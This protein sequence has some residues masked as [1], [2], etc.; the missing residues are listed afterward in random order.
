[1][2]V[3]QARAFLREHGVRNVLAQFVDIHGAPKTKSVPIAHLEDV[4]TNGAGFAG[5][6][7]WGLGMEPQDPDFEAIGDLS[8]LCLLPWQP[9]YARIICS[10][11]VQGR[12]WPYDTRNILQTQ[13][14]RLHDRGMDLNTG[15][16]PEF[17]LL[18]RT[19]DGGVAPADPTDQ[20]MKPCYDYRSLSRNR[21]FLDRFV[22]AMEAVG[23]DVVQADHED[24]NGQFEVNTMYADALESADRLVFIKMAVTEIAHE[25]GMIGTFMPK[26]MTDRT[27]NGLHFHLSLCDERGTNLF[28]DTGDERG[29]DLSRMAYNFLGGLMHHAPALCALSAPTVNSYKRLVIG[30]SLSG[31]PWAPAYVSFGADNR[32]AMVRVPG[33]RLENRI[34]DG[35]ANP[36]LVTA[37]HIVA[38]MDGVER[39]L[40][41]GDPQQLNFYNEKPA[42]MEAKGIPT[43][44]QNLSDAVDALEADTLFAEQLGQDFIREYIN[45][46]RQEWVEYHRQVSHWELDQYLQYP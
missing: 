4:I 35:A 28:E 34:A 33:G 37:A 23:I 14:K 31:A 22:D 39:E 27:G 29:M 17:M 41:P 11:H 36:Y 3:E 13:L 20:L 40:D 25:L 44:P 7:A 1:M 12:P 16:E 21:E 18:R 10:G 8:T 24:G 32:S 6:A 26:P 46:K 9:G 30:Q 45:L 19:E 5:F 42:D 38:G 43:L 15:I 2:S